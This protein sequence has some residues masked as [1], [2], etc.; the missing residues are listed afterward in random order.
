M[1]FCLT[2]SLPALGRW[3]EEEH[4]RFLKALDMYGRN[5]KKVGEMVKT[6]SLV[7][8]RTHA[9]KHYMKLERK[10]TKQVHALITAKVSGDLVC[11]SLLYPFFLLF[12]FQRALKK[13]SPVIF[14]MDSD[15]GLGPEPSP[16]SVADLK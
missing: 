2:T 13:L 16:V 6:R 1:H 5:W 7:Q 8:I 15:A 10:A 11:S 9:Q 14:D 3:T 4:T 12:S